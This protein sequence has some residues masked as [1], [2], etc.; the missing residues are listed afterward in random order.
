MSGANIAVWLSDRAA[1]DPNL[2]SI[3]QGDTILT[4]GALDAASRRFATILGEHGVRPG[5]RVALIIPNVAY[6]PIAYY[7]ILRCGAVVVPMNPLLKAGEIA[8]AWSDSGAEVAVVFPLFAEEA[9]RAASTT[10]TK[11]IVTVPQEFERR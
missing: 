7:A 11:V 1:S 4:F 3:K 8:Y 9:Q 2:P 10:G 5:D 6:F